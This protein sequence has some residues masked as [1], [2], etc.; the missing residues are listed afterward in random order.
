MR[1]FQ[2]LLLR[3]TIL[4]LGGEVHGPEDDQ[5][6][7]ALPVGVASREP[8]DLRTNRTSGAEHTD[9]ERLP[10][11]RMID[12]FEPCKLYLVSRKIH[13]NRRRVSNRY[14]TVSVMLEV[15][16]LTITKPAGKQPHR[17]N[18]V[19]CVRYASPD[20]GAHGHPRCEVHNN[21][22]R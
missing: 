16:P 11:V 9:P 19:K 20:R 7:Y 13:A 3:N 8:F 15:V 21:D 2:V 14:S 22:K 6:C 17:T 1:L 10:S 12:G 4:V 18:L 5:L